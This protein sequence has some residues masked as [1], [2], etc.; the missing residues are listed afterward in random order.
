MSIDEGLVQAMLRDNQ[1]AAAAVRITRLEAQVLDLGHK[2]TVLL[3]AVIGL[4]SQRDMDVVRIAELERVI[5]G[6][7]ASGIGRRVE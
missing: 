6:L 1:A 5:A 3:R 7:M 4:Q 2:E